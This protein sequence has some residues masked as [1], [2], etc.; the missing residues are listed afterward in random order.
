MPSAESFTGTSAACMLSEFNSR[1]SDRSVV[2]PAITAIFRPLRSASRA[3]FD[4]A[5]TSALPPST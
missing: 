3:S 4:F 1:T 2:V 5:A